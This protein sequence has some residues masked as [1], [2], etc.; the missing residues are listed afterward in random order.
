[1]KLGFTF[2]IKY[3]ENIGLNWKQTLKLILE[4][5]PW[6]YIRLP[7]YWDKVETQKG[8]LDYTSIKE[9]LEIVS[10]YKIKIIP[11]IGYRNPRWPERHGPNW[12][13]YMSHQDFNKELLRWIEQCINELRPNH[14]ISTWQ[15]ENEPLENNWG[16]T[17]F[18][19]SEFYTQE[20][21]L[22]KTL[23]HRECLITYGFKPWSK[24]FKNPPSE[25]IIGLDIYSKLGI[26]KFGKIWYL[27]MFYL[28]EKTILN[29]IQQDIEFA[30]QHNTKIWITELQAEPWDAVEGVLFNKNQW[31]KTITPNRF[32]KILD[33]SKKA[34]ISTT[35]V[36]GVEWWW[37][38][39]KEDRSEFLYQLENN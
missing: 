37:T 18:N 10:Q 12:L 3:C 1:M 9:Q 28:P 13:D 24:T 19:V 34:N 38:L 11:V 6:E 39:D 21:E 25:D 27:D 8:K 33:L 7:I 2:S 15:I 22:V 16:E 5:Y 4:S 29:R 17:G 32:S 14:S 20:I 35:L 31:S 26:K 23:D 36:W 30:K